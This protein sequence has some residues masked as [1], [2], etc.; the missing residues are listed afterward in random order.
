MDRSR[1]ATVL[2]VEDDASV[3]L[4]VVM[5]LR[6][7]GYHTVEAN[8]GSSGLMRFKDNPE[9]IDLILTD[10]NMPRMSGPEMVQA[11]LATHPQ[12]RIL[13][14]AGTEG[15]A[16]LP[17]GSGISLLHKPFTAQQLTSRVRQCLES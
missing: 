1:P 9:G 5:C 14:I 17:I 13:F 8:H 2:V 12:T 10:V 15:A 4:F 7:Y 16:D 3:R 6:E 11:I